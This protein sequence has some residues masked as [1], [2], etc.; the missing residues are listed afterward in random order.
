MWILD[1]SMVN[2]WSNLVPN[3][4]TSPSP[5][6]KFSHFVLPHFILLKPWSPLMVD[7]WKAFNEVVCMF[8]SSHFLTNIA[9]YILFII[10]LSLKINSKNDFS[11]IGFSRQSYFSETWR[12]FLDSSYKALKVIN[13][14]QWHRAF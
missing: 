2:W 10:L 7:H 5:T 12:G 11:T 3:A 9:K 14:N 6:P 13:L 4:Q 1:E 8:V